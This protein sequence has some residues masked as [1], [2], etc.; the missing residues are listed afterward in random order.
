MAIPM[1][2]V[3]YRYN[4]CDTFTLS[5]RYFF[6]SL[7]KKDADRALKEAEASKD[8]GLTFYYNELVKENEF[9]P[10]FGEIVEDITNQIE[11]YKEETG[12][13][14]FACDLF[15]DSEYAT[16]GYKNAY[17]FWH[18]Y[19]LISEY[20]Q[21]KELVKECLK[22]NENIDPRIFLIDKYKE[23]EEHILDY[24]ITFTN[25]VTSSNS[26]IL[27][28]YFAVNK[29][30]LGWLAKHKDI[31]DFE[32]FEDLCFYKNFGC[33]FFSC[34]HEKFSSLDELETLN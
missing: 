11:D 16:S 1:S 3:L 19:N 28:F 33:E 12:S 25:K 27:T 15:A 23:L 5:M 26:L 13:Y 10:E 31:Y 29:K 8:R 34:T 14:E 6:T 4:N 2:E 7:N 9:L 30:T 17:L 24:K 22:R 20:F 21:R 18:F 32:G